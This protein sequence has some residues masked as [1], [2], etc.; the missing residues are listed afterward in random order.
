MAFKNEF[1]RTVDAMVAELRSL[2][3][4]AQRTNSVPFRSKPD[5]VQD[6]YKALGLD[7]ARIRRAANR[8]E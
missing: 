2:N 3:K 5:P 4:K 8:E 1:Q 6:T 7:Q